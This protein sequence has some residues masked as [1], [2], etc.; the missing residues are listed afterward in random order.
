MYS[1]ASVEVRAS[2]ENNSP[3]AEMNARVPRSTAST[4]PTS[5]ADTPPNIQA[6]ANPGRAVQL[7]RTTNNTAAI[8]LPTTIERP[9]RPPSNSKSKVSLSRSLLIAELATAGAMEKIAA[10]RQ[11]ASA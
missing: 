7:S 11:M 4:T 1:A 3:S 2:A 6:I 8:S 10:S 9:R 5:R